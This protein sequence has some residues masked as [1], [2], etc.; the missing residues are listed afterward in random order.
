MANTSTSEA[1]AWLG[2]PRPALKR[3]GTGYTRFV[4]TMKFLLPAT[5]GVLVLMVVVWPQ[6]R[7]TPRGMKLGPAAIRVD[8]LGG[9]KLVNARFTG[10]DRQDQPYT[11]TADALIQDSA[12]A[13]E[14]DLSNPKADVALNGG[15]WLAVRAPTGRFRRK[16]QVLDLSGGVDLFH[17][18]GYQLHTA[19]ARLLLREGRAFG[20][21]PVR[22]QGPGGVLTATGFRIV[23][24]GTRILFTGKARLVVYP[25]NRSARR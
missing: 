10:S 7:D 15:N 11:V 22:A 12:E 4:G 20:D 2:R 6:F 16:S 23:D 13:D 5:A 1:N 18:N 3:I 24:G 19:D 14:V 9:Q 25:R 17:D 21:S 8:D